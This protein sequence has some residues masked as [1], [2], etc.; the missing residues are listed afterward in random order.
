MAFFSD[1]HQDRKRAR[2][3]PDIRR[4]SLGN[5]D[6]LTMGL[7]LTIVLPPLL[8]TLWLGAKQTA[9]FSLSMQ[10]ANILLSGIL[11]ISIFIFH[12][13]NPTRFSLLLILLLGGAVFFEGER[14]ASLPHFNP[15]RTF[16]YSKT[17]L[18]YYSFFIVLF[19]TVMSGVIA[20]H[21]TRFINTPFS[22]KSVY[23][24]FSIF[25]LI[26]S[27]ISLF[28]EVIPISEFF[29]DHLIPI[30][31]GLLGIQS[32]AALIFATRKH[33]SPYRAD[34]WLFLM[35]LSLL[36]PTLWI[37]GKQGHSLLFDTIGQ[38]LS[39][40]LGYLFLFAGLLARSLRILQKEK[41]LSAIANRQTVAIDILNKGTS[42][43]T[44]STSFTDALYK[45]VKILTRFGQWDLG[46]ALVINPETDAFKHH[47]F[48]D[49]PERF[50]AFQKATIDKEIEYGQG[51]TGTIWETCQLS[52]LT[53]VSD[54]TDF[55]RLDAFRASGLKSGFGLPVI[56][57]NKT[58]AILEFFRTKP[59]PL[60]TL[61]LDISKSITELLAGLYV[62][63]S[64]TQS[65]A[66]QETLVLEL[67]EKLPA[68]IATFDQHDR[69]IL[70]NDRFVRFN[71][72]FKGIIEPGLE[73][74]E[75]LTAS[76]YSGKV[77][78]AVGS[79]QHWIQRRLKEHKQGHDWILQKWS[80]GRIL[81]FCEIRLPSSG[82]IEIWT[83]TAGFQPSETSILN[84]QSILKDMLAGIPAG[85]CIFD[86]QHILVSCNTDLFEMLDL[87]R[88]T[89]KEGSHYTDLI[90]FLK[91][92]LDR[93][94]DLI[95]HLTSHAESPNAKPRAQTVP[96]VQLGPDIV[97]LQI[98][99]FSQ[100]GLVLCL[101]KHTTQPYGTTNTTA[102]QK[103]ATGHCIPEIQP[104]AHKKSRPSVI[105][106]P[107][108][109]NELTDVLGTKI[110]HNLV[111]KMFDQ[112]EIRYREI[113]T[114]HHKKDTERLR[115]EVHMLKSIFGQFG[116]M[117][118]SSV[119]IQ[120]DTLC[121]ENKYD[122]AFKRIPELLQKCDEAIEKLHEFANADFT[123]KPGSQTTQD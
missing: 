45:N 60:D 75:L 102:A 48:S 70:F 81:Q 25:F 22:S 26:T 7:I 19:L 111:R 11:F 73:F 91:I 61:F 5:P 15:M 56:V 37:F 42:I 97:S 16:D 108:F 92:D 34:F 80:D 104:K 107:H 93:N 99:H 89:F 85:I 32:G 100:N 17:A 1:S 54:N 10:S 96:D 71:N 82:S 4:R 52:C 90:R 41:S 69:L 6:Y 98:T 113:T 8:A 53:D 36:F 119:A 83:D 23:L 18:S 64:H 86:D 76:A 3:I 43:A 9:E 88:K 103:D 14:F 117:S 49:T 29:A 68:G 78:D 120:I 106:D 28:G 114:A 87:N 58:V 122:K 72:Q 33:L 21:R 30:L 51:F 77:T 95:F 63:V 50:A 59:A 74:V 13:R 109:I 12:Y 123:P 94:R 110:V 40:T 118:A 115:R 112:Y 66:D 62:R 105:L 31:L 24:L 101:F 44:A 46:H 39:R 121:K 47:W 20:L 55:R 57:D 65:I 116:L 79:E 35:V 38:E 27:G 2:V 67:L 84:N